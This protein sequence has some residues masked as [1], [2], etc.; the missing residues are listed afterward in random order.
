LE[1]VPLTGKY[2]DG[3]VSVDVL[4]AASDSCHE[5]CKK[6]QR[7]GAKDVKGRKGTE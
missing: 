3:L 1:L 7:D 6:A 5:T 4:D 2:I